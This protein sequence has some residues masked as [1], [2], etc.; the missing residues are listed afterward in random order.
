[1]ALPSLKNLHGKW[2]RWISRWHKS[3]PLPASAPTRWNPILK[4]T[5]STTDSHRSELAAAMYSIISTSLLPYVLNLNTCANIWKTIE[6]CLQTMNR[7][8]LLHIKNELH[9]LTM[10]NLSMTQYLSAI[11]AKVDEITSAGATIDIE[12]IILYT[13]NGLPSSYNAFKTVIKTNLSPISFDDLYSLLCSEE[14]NQQIEALKELQHLSFIDKIALAAQRGWGRGRFTTNRGRSFSQPFKIDRNSN[15]PNQLTQVTK[16]SKPS[17]NNITCQICGKQV[18]SALKCWH[19]HDNNYNGYTTYPRAFIADNSLSNS[20]ATTVWIL[21]TWAS[22]HLTSDPNQLLHPQPYQ[23]H[24]QVHLG[25]NSTLPIQHIGKGILPT[26]SSKLLLSNLLHVPNLSYNL[27][28]VHHLTN[29]NNCFITF[30]A[31]GYF[32]FDRKTNQLL[33]KGPCHQG[34]YVIKSAIAPTTQDRH[35]ALLSTHSISNLWHKRLDHPS[36]STLSTLSHSNQDICI[37][38]PLNSCDACQ[39]AKS[40]K[41]HFSLSTSKSCKPLELIHSDVWGPSA[42]QSMSGFRYYLVLI[43]DYS[44]HTWTFPLKAKSETSMVI[45]HFKNMVERQFSTKVKIIRTDGGKE[46]H[47]KILSSLFSKWGIILQYTCPYTP[48]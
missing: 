47:N 37:S 43:D 36:K 8:C 39:M 25:D 27:L 20:S 46:Y 9:N 38:F 35:L 5:I 21:D 30:D 42:I 31:N 34:L 23:R 14:S 18:H 44:R 22:S 11:K 33:L 48:E 13:L 41:L 12:D 28:S 7:S 45:T 24:Q 40:N 10:H 2:V 3:L 32:I 4:P 19:R 15:L 29:D 1:M 6:R 16:F 17:T 26:P